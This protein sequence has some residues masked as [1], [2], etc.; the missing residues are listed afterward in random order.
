VVS[1]PECAHAANRRRADVFWAPIL[2]HSFEKQAVQS[3]VINRFKRWCEPISDYCGSHALLLQI[4]TIAAA[5]VANTPE[6]ECTICL[7]PIPP[8]V[9][10]PPTLSFAGGALVR[11]SVASEHYNKECRKLLASKAGQGLCLQAFGM[12]QAHASH[13]HASPRLFGPPK[14]AI[15]TPARLTAHALAGPVLGH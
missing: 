11:N 12:S 8:T 3:L 6:N 2:T 13:I 7:D 9:S 1:T 5:G 4:L 14:G 15:C 10:A